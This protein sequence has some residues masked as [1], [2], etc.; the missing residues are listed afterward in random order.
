MNNQDEQMIEEFNREYNSF[1]LCDVV[2]KQDSDRL[3]AFLLKHTARVREEERHNMT[4]IPTTPPNKQTQEGG[5]MRIIEKIKHF[6]TT[7][8]P[9]CKVPMEVSKPMDPFRQ[10]DTIYKCPKCKRRFL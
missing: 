2:C 6:F 9:D 3:K 7:K 1:K 5:E 4:N 8:C 10:T